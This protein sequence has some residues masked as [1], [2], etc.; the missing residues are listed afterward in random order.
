MASLPVLE[1]GIPRQA[2]IQPQAGVV[3]PPQQQQLQQDD[4]FQKLHN[5][6]ADCWFEV[7]RLAESMD[8]FDKAVFA[9]NASL[10]YNPY[11]IATLKAIA[12]IYRS[13]EKF[14]KAVEFYKSILNLNQNSGDIWGCLGMFSMFQLF[15]SFFSFFVFLRLWFSCCCCTFLGYKLTVWYH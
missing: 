1:Q 7:G 15:F 14:A 10:R 4:P 5:E 8:D 2:L 9:F 13:K 12:N 3:Q 6:T 11:N